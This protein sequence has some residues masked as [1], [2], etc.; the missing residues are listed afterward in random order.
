MPDVLTFLLTDIEGSTALWELDPAT[1]A[2]ALE[3]HDAIVDEVVG[4]AGGTVVKTRGEG[5][6]TF[7]VFRLASEAVTAAAE[8]V[9]ALRTEPWA[10][11]T[12][13]HVRASVLTG[14]VE[15]RHGD[16]YG[17]TV[18]RAARLRGAASGDQV[19]V[20]G[21]T[22]A[23]VAD[24][25]PAGVELVDLGTHALRDLARP[26]RIFELVVDA[27][28]ESRPVSPTP[29]RV[30]W[31]G[32]A[33]GAGVVGR[34]EELARLERAW[35]GTRAGTPALALVCGEPGIGKTTLAAALAQ[36]VALDDAVVLHGCW[37]DGAIAP[38][39]A[40]R[41]A[42]LARAQSAPKTV[43]RAELG[44]AAGEV[45]RLLPELGERLGGVRPVVPG[46]PDA[47]RLRLFEGVAGWLRAI[48]RTHPVLLVLDDL[49]W[50]DPA[51]LRLLEH[52]LSSDAPGPLLVVLTSRTE[53][54]ED[55]EHL[56]LLGALPRTVDVERISL[57]GLDRAQLGELLDPAVVDDVDLGRWLHEETGGNPFFARKLLEHVTEV[58][59]SRSL[60]PSAVRDVVRWRLAQLSPPA[61]DVLAVAGII[62]AAFDLTILASACHLTE[63]EVLDVVDDA[64]RA[65]LAHEVQ[66][67]GER[68]AFSHAV[69]RRTLADSFSRSRAA[70]IHRRVAEAFE[71]RHGEA[72]AAEL[73]H[74]YA[75]AARTG[76]VSQAVRWARAAAGQARHR[77]AF[78][79]AVAI[80]ERVLEVLHEDGDGDA[81]TR[82]EVLLELA[83]ALDW[84][85]ES[86]QRDARYL[87][88]AGLAR[89]LRRPDLF[90]RA[91][92]GYRGWL[93]RATGPSRRAQGLLEEALGLLAPDDRRLR[94]MVLARLAQLLHFQAR[95]DRRRTLCDEATDLAR[96]LGDPLVLAVVLRARAWALDGPYD[97]DEQVVLGDEIE[98]I[99][100]DV[101]DDE[102]VLHGI[103]TRLGGLLKIGD[104]VRIRADTVRLTEMAGRLRHPEHLRVVGLLGVATAAQEGR[105]EEAEIEAEALRHRL[106]RLGH[107]QTDLIHLL[108]ILPVDFFRHR[109]DHLRTLEVGVALQPDQLAGVGMLSLAYAG[110]GEGERLVALLAGRSPGE[111]RDHD[112]NFTWWPS[113]VGFAVG[114][115]ACADRRWAAVVHD[116]LR[117]HAGRHCFVGFVGF[118]GAVDHHL[119]ALEAVLG[120]L[121][122]A[123]DHLDAAL[124]VHRSVAARPWTALTAR[125]LADVLRAR[126]AAGDEAR[127]RHLEREATEI[128]GEVG[129]TWSGAP[130][131]ALR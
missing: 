126:L 43:L 50:A 30:G 9:R 6:A 23:L 104:V 73:A 15:G 59:G 41:E 94:A 48:G 10:P 46:T 96:T 68:Y 34:V 97:A 90:T 16:W 119:G 25:L 36:R 53:P 54:Q 12:P 69:V 125:T 103:T 44:S 8:L 26:E 14:E 88:A 18:N 86:R 117:P 51:S 112:Q 47:E 106:D 99:G 123:V 24:S 7:C 42:L 63:D 38:F 85:G 76:T 100:Q 80:L 57:R 89:A 56:R 4:A 13:L 75:M 115:A 118:F 67:T 20:A 93:P 128:A 33:V 102:L 22:A 114:A 28:V 27:E 2:V 3:R 107:P 39:Q 78:E 124:A 131:A 45:A 91:A 52:V 35:A 58:G 71:E 98:R 82:A 32:R 122:S 49:H 55:R 129:L 109:T 11:S 29:S 60:V 66:G 1:M 17:R 65:G 81:A 21:A 5:D 61:A 79:A 92:L 120:H 110:A 101:G 77:V 121:D 83:D 72:A 19:L 130:A 37:H 95:W 87:E 116:L 70:R 31:V 74:H 62:G 64:C 113:V 111:L 105:F 108:G 40:W 84:A 127:A